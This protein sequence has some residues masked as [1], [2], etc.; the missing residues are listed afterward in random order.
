MAI[1][2]TSFFLPVGEMIVGATD[3]GICLFDYRYRKNLPAIQQRISTGLNTTFQEGVHPLFGQLKSEMDEYFNGH[4]QQFDLPLLLLGSSFQKKVWGSLLG[5][6]FGQTRSYLQQARSLGDT[7]AVRAIASANG[8]N[9]LA[10]LIPCHRV[11]G[12]DG[13][14][15]GYAGGLTA[16]RKLLQHEQTVLG[17]AQ[18]ATLF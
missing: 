3:A 1:W 2:T 5:I 10:I 6:P 15:T 17:Q 13:S 14:L 7:Q 4:R 12:A 18:Q 9:G 16:K 8:A 11:L